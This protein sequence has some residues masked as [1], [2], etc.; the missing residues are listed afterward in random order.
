MY[1]HHNI[2]LKEDIIKLTDLSPRLRTLHRKKA[3]SPSGTVILTLVLFSNGLS[4]CLWNS[5]KLVYWWWWW[6]L[7]RAWWWYWFCIPPPPFKLCML[8]W[9]WW[10]WWCKVWCCCCCCWPPR[11]WWWE[12]PP[13]SPPLWLWPPPSLHICLP[14]TWWSIPVIRGKERKMFKNLYK[15]A[16]IGFPQS[17][18]FICLVA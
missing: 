18:T 14:W 2:I 10:W 6:W 5:S 3:L 7:T 17:Y 11:W 8:L 12:E 15:K 1:M 16:S 9:W 4:I 13:I